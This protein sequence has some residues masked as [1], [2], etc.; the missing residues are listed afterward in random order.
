MYAIQILVLA[1]IFPSF[2]FACLKQKQV[3]K[4]HA[5]NMNA[6]NIINI[7]F[8]KDNF[9]FFSIVMQ[10]LLIN[11]LILAGEP[12]GKTGFM[13]NFRS[14]SLKIPNMSRLGLLFCVI[15]DN[16]IILNLA[17]ICVAVRVDQKTI[18]VAG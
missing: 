2:N 16:N 4:I 13:A 11:G 10:L 18:L 15:S 8:Y 9:S 7:L 17:A 1:V 6:F 5:L 12:A 3:L 14:R